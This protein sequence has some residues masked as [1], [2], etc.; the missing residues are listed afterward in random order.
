LRCWRPG[1]VL[2][3]KL[4]FNTFSSKGDCFGFLFLCTLFNT[5][6]S[7]AP[8]IPL[9]RRMLGSNPGQLRLRHWLSDSL[10]TRLDLI[11]DSARSHPH[12]ARSH[13]HCRVIFNFGAMRKRLANVTLASVLRLP[14]VKVV[15]NRYLCS[16]SLPGFFFCHPNWMQRIYVVPFLFAVAG[17]VPFVPSRLAVYI[18]PLSVRFYGCRSLFLVPCRQQ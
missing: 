18:V 13:S 1:L 10:T 16:S 6:S 3:A 4:V 2:I 9:C 15:Y 14:A 12:S 8:Q 7:N 5:A 17:T 11:Y